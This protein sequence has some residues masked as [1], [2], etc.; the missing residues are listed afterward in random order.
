MNNRRRLEHSKNILHNNKTTKYTIQPSLLTT[1]LYKNYNVNFVNHILSDLEEFYEYI[2]CNK[3]DDQNDGLVEGSLK[4]NINDNVKSRIIVNTFENI[5]NTF[6]SYIDIFKKYR[7]II[8]L[9]RYKKIILNYS[10]Y[11]TNPIKSIDINN[12]ADKLAH[13][14][15][16]IKQMTESKADI[17]KAIQLEVD[18]DQQIPSCIKEVYD[19]KEDGEILEVTD[20]QTNNPYKESGYCINIIEIFNRYIKIHSLKENIQLFHKK[21]DNG[22]LILESKNHRIILSLC[23]N[24]QDPEWNILEFTQNKDTTLDGNKNDL[25]ENNN[26]LDNNE[27]NNKENINNTHNINIINLI[28][29]NNDIIKNI[30]SYER[31]YCTMLNLNS[32]YNKYKYYIEDMKGKNINMNISG[33]YHDFNISILENIYVNYKYNNYSIYATVTIDNKE[34]IKIINIRNGEESWSS[35][36]YSEEEYFNNVEDILIFHDKIIEE[37]INENIK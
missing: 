18:I 15:L 8:R 11:D 5:T 33:N 21:I 28:K 35:N 1:L 27:N 17:K 19:K 26:N 36:F 9:A 7:T 6:N 31:I 16:C 24:V 34:H 32:I 12:V 22:R 3:I 10:T 2:E 23:N 20:K 4:N 25:N 14:F 30:I 29:N 13:K 37:N